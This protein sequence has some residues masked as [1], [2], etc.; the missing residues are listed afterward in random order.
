[1]DF[2]QLPIGF[3][4]KGAHGLTQVPHHFPHLISVGARTRLQGLLLCEIRAAELRQLIA[5]DQPL[6]GAMDE[7][8]PG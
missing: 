6:V 2:F 3:H 4:L 7:I 8:A 5:Q 1:M